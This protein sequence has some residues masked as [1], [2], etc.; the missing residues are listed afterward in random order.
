MNCSQVSSLS[1]EGCSAVVRPDVFEVAPCRGQEWG[2][3]H[4]ELPLPTTTLPP[5]VAVPMGVVNSRLGCC[6]GLLCCA[7]VVPSTGT[8]KCIPRK[9]G[10][11]CGRGSHLG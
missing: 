5:S 4:P 3:V 7:D 10:I 1:F 8:R 2:P 11:S 9:W 6:M